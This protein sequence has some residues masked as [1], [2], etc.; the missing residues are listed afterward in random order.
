MPRSTASRKS[1]WSKWIAG[2]TWANGAPWSTRDAAFRPLSS[3]D[4][5]HRCHGC[6]RTA[7]FAELAEAL[8]PARGKSAG[9]PQR[10]LRPWF[11]EHE[12]RRIGLRYQPKV[13]CTVKLSRRLYPQHRRHNLDS[14]IE[15]HGLSCDNRHRALADARVLWEFT[16]QIHLDSG[17][18]HRRE[19][20]ED[21]CGNR[22][23]R[24]ACRPDML[25]E[26]PESAGV[27]VFYGEDNAA[28]R[29]Q[30]RWTCERGLSRISAAIT[31]R[32]AMRKI[33]AEMARNRM[34]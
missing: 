23:C 1:V 28:V 9:G 17:A 5:H 24:R 30:E 18:R 7:T 16:S 22:R 11:P 26:I 31:V 21:S 29:R 19:A 13:L 15:R 12:F 6:E 3:A 8:H 34:D 33:A 2:V 25:D 4:W 14:L 27:Y 10:S 20:V 32:K